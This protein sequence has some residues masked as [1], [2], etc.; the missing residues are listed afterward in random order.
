LTWSGPAPGVTSTP[1]PRRSTTD[2]AAPFALETFTAPVSTKH[3]VRSS[4]ASTAQ[5]VP[6]T[7]VIASG[8]NIWKSRRRSVG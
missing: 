5:L 8:V 7:A 1:S 4:V 6:R 3:E 2:F